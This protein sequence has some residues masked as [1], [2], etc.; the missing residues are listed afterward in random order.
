MMT[1]VYPAIVHKEDDGSWLE[2]PDLPGC[3]TQGD[4]LEELMENAEEALGAY[5]AVKMEYK[6]EIPKASDISD[7]DTQGNDMKTYVKAD[8]NKYHKDTKAVKK[9][10]SIPAWLAKEAESR[11]YSLSK[12]LQEALMEKLSI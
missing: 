2:F 4:N 3:F 11:N 1:R 10:L 8:V 7:I 9:M 12:I 5:I 6:E